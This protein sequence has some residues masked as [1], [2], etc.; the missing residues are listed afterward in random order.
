MPLTGFRKIA[1]VNLPTRWATFRLSAF[2]ALRIH[3]ISRLRQVETAVALVLG[4]LH[5]SP[6]PLVRIHSQCT[7]GDAFTSL[8]CD[9][10]DQLHLAMHAIAE[11]G[12]GVLVYEYQEGRG[13]G[14]MEKLRAYELQDQ[15]LDTIEANL[16]LGHEVDARDYE[17]PARILGFLK[18]R[19]LRLMTNNPKKIHAVS[20]SGIEVC[21]RVSADVPLG[22]HSAHYVATKRAKLGHLSGPVLPLDI[23]STGEMQPFLG[24]ETAS[25][26]QRTHHAVAGHCDL[27]RQE[28]T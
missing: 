22:K 15:G 18:V 23:S 14:L 5:T 24:P 19:S 6:P 10:H 25:P 1:E 13:I 28:I 4:D 7:T 8:R 16:Q 27:L 26:Q 20:S 21:G 3:R 9:C 11:A 2:E 12:T 17:L